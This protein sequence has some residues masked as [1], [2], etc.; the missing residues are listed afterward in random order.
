[1]ARYFL[2]I[3]HGDVLIAD[4]EGGE[5]VDEAAALVEAR[6]AAR[7]LVINAIRTGRLIDDSRIEVWNAGRKPVGVVRLVDV[8]PTRCRLSC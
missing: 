4:P 7:D 8:L 5:F 3:H 2:H 6:S 1:M